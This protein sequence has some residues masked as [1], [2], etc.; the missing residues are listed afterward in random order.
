MTSSGASES[1]IC[2]ARALALHQAGGVTEPLHLRLHPLH[3]VVLD[4]GAELG[5]L[6]GERVDLVGQLLVALRLGVDEAGEV[7][8][9]ARPQVRALAGLGAD[10][11]QRPAEQRRRPAYR[12]ATPPRRLPPRRLR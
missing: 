7:V 11:E 3:G 4:L 8:V 10:H 6:V 2:D 5:H 1:V 12:S 9:A